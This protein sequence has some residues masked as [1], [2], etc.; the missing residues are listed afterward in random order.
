[1]NEPVTTGDAGGFLIHIR[2]R[3]FAAFREV[4]LLDLSIEPLGLKLRG[5]RE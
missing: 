2:P 5:G 4:E 3:L 1:M